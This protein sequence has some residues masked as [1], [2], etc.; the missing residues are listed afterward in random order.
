MI[1][2]DEVAHLRAE[3]T[4]PLDLKNA[5]EA[6]QI[7]E[8]LNL[9]HVK[10]GVF[11]INAV[12]RAK[13]I[14]KQ[15]FFSAL[16]NGCG[17]CDVVLG[18]DIDDQLC[19]NMQCTGWNSGYPDA[20]INIISQSGRKIPFEPRSLLFLADFV[21]QAA[22]VSPRTI[23]QNVIQRANSMGFIP[24]AACEYEFSMFAENSDSIRTKNFHGLM[25]ISPGNF[26][27]SMLRSS[28]YSEFYQE[29]LDNC[30]AMN[31]PIEGLHTEI[32]PG[33]LEAALAY[34]K[35]LQA[36]DKAALFKTMTKVIAQRYGWMATFM[37]KP[38]LQQQGQSGHLH[39]SLR[40][41]NDECVFYAKGQPA[42][43]SQIMQ[44]FVAGQQKYLPELLALLAPNINSFARLVPGYWA[45]TQA[46]WGIDNRTTAL[47]I[48][49]GKQSA[50]RVEYRVAGADSNPYL[51]MAAAIASGIAGIEQQLDLP[52]PVSGNAYQVKLESE[53][54]FPDNLKTAANCFKNSSLA[55]DWFG[56]FFVKDYA[57]KCEWEVREMQKQVTNW[58]LERYFELV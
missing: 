12:L 33:V 52:E 54:Q 49:A 17:F 39:I 28:V 36:A 41:L 24:Y 48:I 22:A 43:M 47:R 25:P 4:A 40:G 56:D 50:Q 6:R 42:N 11:D 1:V 23:L 27:Y 53:Y 44:H 8:D 37:A 31:L 57:A 5:Q 55:A 16:E 14:S 58:Q 2:D 32:G 30:Q 21:G 20:T 26:G 9:D 34:D 29:L 13:Y 7:I 15:K 35:A 19:D 3:N 10:I 51:V 46:S 45:P 18:S 38:V